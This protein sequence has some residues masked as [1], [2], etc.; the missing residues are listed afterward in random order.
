MLDEHARSK[1]AVAAVVA[2]LLFACHRVS[3]PTE[4]LAVAR[5]A[6]PM[7]YAADLCERDAD[8]AAGS[9]CVCDYYLG[10]A[11]SP[12]TQNLCQPSN[13][14]VDADCGVGGNCSPSLVLHCGTPVVT[15]YFCHRAGD[16]CGVDGD[17]PS[18]EQCFYATEVGHWTCGDTMRQC[19]GG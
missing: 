8:C 15:G 7:T 19:G 16:E 9:D 2:A 1:L 11:G 18:G 4:H 14:R 3:T 6:C 10:G 12:G 17:C 13:C 5:A